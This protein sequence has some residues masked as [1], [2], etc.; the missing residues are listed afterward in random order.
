MRNRYIRFFISS[1]FADMA[2]ERDILQSLFARLSEEYAQKDWQIEAVDLHWGISQEAGFDNKTMQICK[3]EIKR[4]QQLSP[5]PNFIVLL[6]NR[7]GWTP[8][9][10]TIPYKIGKSLKMSTT[11]KRLFNRW[12]RLDENALPDGEYVLQ[13]RLEQYRDA[14]TWFDEVEYPL[15]QMFLRNAARLKWK[16]WELIHHSNHTI[17]KLFGESATA[18]EI[19]IG[20]LSVPDAKD[21]VIAYIRDLADIPDHQ[22]KVFLEKGEKTIH[23]LEKLKNE[24][25]QKLQKENILDVSINY[26]CYSTKKYDIDFEHEI[27][28][29]IR[30]VIENA[31]ADYDS[32]TATTEDEIHLGIA[33]EEAKGFVGREKELSDIHQYIID[34]NE[35]RP[36]WI[37]GPSGSGKSALL[38]KVIE[39][40]RDTHNIICRFCGRTP[41][42]LYSSDLNFIADSWVNDKYFKEHEKPILIVLDA[43][44][45]LDDKSNLRFASLE[46]LNKKHLNN[47]KIIVS[48]TDEVKYSQQPPFL[49]VYKL[50]DMGV[51]SVPLVTNILNK[52]D[53]TLTKSQYASLQFV[54]DASDNSAIYLHILG[55]YLKTKASWE[56]IED[57]CSD[58]VYLVNNYLKHLTLPER[59]GQELVGEALGL[60]TK[61]RIGLS[62]KEMLDLLSRN[63]YVKNAVEA[64]SFHQIETLE[65]EWR[66]PSVLWSRLRYELSPF[67]RTYASPAGQV[68]TIFHDE[69]KTI[70]TAIY[71]YEPAQKADIASQLFHYYKEHIHQGNTHALLEIIHSAI[72]KKA[73]ESEMSLIQEAVDFLSSDLDFLL[74]KHRLFPLQLNSDFDEVLPFIEG[75]M[76]KMTVSLKLSLSSLPAKANND[77]LLLYMY[78]LPTDT[79][80]YQLA[81]DRVG[82]MT[83]M[84]NAISD[85]EPEDPTLYVLNEVGEFPCMSDDGTKVA[86][87]F[88]NRHT[89]RITDAVNPHNSIKLESDGEVMELQCDDEMRY[90]AIRYK[91]QCQ[92][93]DIVQEKEICLKHFGDH[94]WMSLSADGKTFAFGDVSTCQVYKLSEKENVFKEYISADSFEGLGKPLTGRLSPSGKIVWLLFNNQNILRCDIEKECDYSFNIEFYHKGKPLVGELYDPYTSILSCTETRFVCYHDQEAIIGTCNGEGHKYGGRDHYWYPSSGHYPIMAV[95]RDGEYLLDFGGQDGWSL[96]CSIDKFCDGNTNVLEPVC[97]FPITGLRAINSDFTIGLNCSRLQIF[98]VS[99]QLKKYTYSY[100]YWFHELYSFS[101][102]LDGLEAVLAP[103]Q[104]GGERKKDVLRISN[105]QRFVW[106]PPLIST[107]FVSTEIAVISPNRDH[108]VV[109]VDKGQ[110]KEFSIISLFR[111]ELFYHKE[112]EGLSWSRVIISL[113]SKYVFF[114]EDGHLNTKDAKNNAVTII[115]DNGDELS[116]YLL[117]SPQNVGWHIKG[118]VKKQFTS[119]DNRFLYTMY[120]CGEDAHEKGEISK[121]VYEVIDLISQKYVVINDQ[122]DYPISVFFIE[123]SIGIPFYITLPVPGNPIFTNDAEKNLLCMFNLSKHEMRRYNMDGYRAIGASCTGRFTFISNEKNEIFIQQSFYGSREFYGGL[124]LEHIYWVIPAL[125]EAHIYAITDDFE[126][127][128]YNIISKEIEQRAYRGAF[129]QYQVCARGLYLLADKGDLALFQPDAQ[130]NVNVPAVT[131]F[132]RRWNLKTKQQEEP[133]AVCPMCGHVFGLDNKL[134][135]VIKEGQNLSIFKYISHSDWDNPKLFG[136]YCPHCHAELRFNPYII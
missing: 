108:I 33:A 50:S 26:S 111:N 35:H 48:T 67:L 42:T 41:N 18:Q 27:E 83:A 45:Q 115:D 132:V 81:K 10:E 66:L 109:S 135:D 80:L 61:E 44:N 11:E 23:K 119:M 22:E 85:S 20:A 128:L 77:Q 103:G 70:F 38:A 59:H 12:Y 124:I 9:P 68:T 15:S 87:V 4:C 93:F 131:T 64:N 8:L 121:G 51:D 24:L 25:R 133:T 96:L 56:I 46:W 100:N 36:L 63:K 76:R 123:D 74:E 73:T 122:R 112:F 105:F 58:I 17:T 16:I 14:V 97:R 57:N 6:G 98:D 130:Y 52:A 39:Q 1:T 94:G 21:H 92:V 32:T 60:L 104:G 75:E 55:H 95:S 82:S 49:K 84:K 117:P 91:G 106:Q 110:T 69:L 7:Y 2:K 71:L 40:H 13:E 114:Y 47:I 28:K 30:R 79:L 102:S 107:N 126:I 72:V 19:N 136:H 54:I 116:R 125:D 31:I 120:N 43:L 90:L 65:G 127:L 78:S 3:S 118:R 134:K 101:C 86:S 89:I 29:K 53:R 5:R 129:Y 37:K 62:D 99:L 113:D 88:D 34:S